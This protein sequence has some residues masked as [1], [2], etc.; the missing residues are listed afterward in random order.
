MTTEVSKSRII[1]VLQKEIVGLRK[2]L[3]TQTANSDSLA[4][5]LKKLR[6]DV[7]S[8]LS[9]TQQPSSTETNEGLPLRRASLIVDSTKTSSSTELEDKVAGLKYQLTLTLSQLSAYKAHISCF[10]HNICSNH[11][12]F[13]KPSM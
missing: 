6:S 5:D 10:D 3:V 8:V 4:S 13:I 11:P 2:K 1:S 9:S 12:I 7:D